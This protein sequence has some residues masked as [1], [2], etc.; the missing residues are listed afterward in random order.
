M[1]T[2]YPQLRIR[3]DT[4]ALWL[5]MHP[6]PVPCFTP[7]LLESL[8][9]VLR[10]L[11]RRILSDGSDFRYLIGASTVQGVFNLGGQLALFH[12]AVTRQDR[13]ALEHY[14]DACIQVIHG[15]ASALNCPR[16]TTLSLV[17]GDALG[18]GFEAALSAQVLVAERGCRM[19]FPENVFNLFPG[20]G[21]YP[22]LSR[23]TGA[24]LAQEIISGGGLY[25]AETLYEMGAVDILAEKGGGKTAVR[26]Y[27]E[28]R[29]KGTHPP[30]Q[31]IAPT[32]QT[33]RQCTGRWVEAALALPPADLDTIA[34]LIRQQQRKWPAPPA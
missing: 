20:M 33:L 5:N 24:D 18:G 3:S 28:A 31:R 10:T 29:N 4:N 2:D 13:A 6:A 17:E 14:A 15:M 23:R 19:G 12:R 27:I 34:R 26:R 22:L 9:T 7:E 32:L 25:P 8:N 1:Q 16:L 21:A 11:R 30:P